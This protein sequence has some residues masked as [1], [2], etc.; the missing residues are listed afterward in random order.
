MSLPAGG[1]R[2]LSVG[3]VFMPFAYACLYFLIGHPPEK[4]YEH[5]DGRYD[6]HRLDSDFKHA[7]Y[8]TSYEADDAKSYEPQHGLDHERVMGIVPAFLTFNIFVI[9]CLHS[10]YNNLRFCYYKD[11]GG[12]LFTVPVH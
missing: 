8:D 5:K 2:N 9:I 7:E 6:D 3:I 10:L 4:S 1:F 12:K 11:Y